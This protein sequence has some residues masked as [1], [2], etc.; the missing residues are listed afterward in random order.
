M[1]NIVVFGA[2]GRQGKFF[3]FHS[4]SVVNHLLKKGGW[5]IRAVTRNPSSEKAQN[6]LKNGVEVVKGDL[7][8]TPETLYPILKGAEAAFGVTDF[9]TFLN[10]P[11][12]PEAKEVLCGK[13]FADAV[14][15]AKVPF[16]IFSS[17]PSTLKFTDNNI[18]TRHFETK[19]AIE[20]HM[21]Q[22]DLSVIIVRLYAYF[23]NMLFWL[24]EKPENPV[25]L[26]FALPMGSSPMFMTCV[27]ELGGVIAA[28]LD[29]PDEYLNRTVDVVHAFMPLSKV[30]E[31]LSEV[32]QKQVH[33]RPMSIEEYE[34]LPFAFAKDLANMFGCYQIMFD[35]DHLHLFDTETCKNLY[36]QHLTLEQWAQLHK[37]EL[38]VSAK[39]C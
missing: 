21:R 17:L 25:E 4:G 38:L 15:M 6:L 1:K 23:E 9:Q 3:V 20:E 12:G 35:D 36:P 30:A 10:D 27:A 26:E 28:I 24:H 34:R 31:I 39:R 22:I 7:L 19:A 8:Q 14:K 2:T 33:Y 11:E 18:A 13:N 32:L 29:R 5:H 37:E 16:P